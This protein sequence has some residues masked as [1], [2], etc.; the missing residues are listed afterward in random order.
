MEEGNWNLQEDGEALL[1]RMKDILFN[2]WVPSSR[3][4]HSKMNQKSAGT[5]RTTQYIC[6]YVY[7]YIC[8]Y[9]YMYICIY[10]YMYICIYVYMYICIYVYT[11]PVSEVFVFTF[12]NITSSNV[13]LFA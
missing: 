6:I 8:V 7:M 10:V 1:N 9:V 2:R 3:N 13:H 4:F 5:F 12:S 11:V